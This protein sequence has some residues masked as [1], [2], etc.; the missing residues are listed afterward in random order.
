MRWVS[1]DRAP[2]CV[3]NSYIISEC[4]GEH[5]DIQSGPVG[6]VVEVIPSFGRQL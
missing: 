6:V 5:R 1:L 4:D 2:Q 3:I